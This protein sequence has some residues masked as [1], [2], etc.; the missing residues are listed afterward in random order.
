MSDLTFDN[1]DWE[2]PEQFYREIVLPRIEQLEKGNVLIVD[3]AEDTPIKT[4]LRHKINKMLRTCRHASIG[5]AYILHRIKSG[6]WTQQ[7]SSSCK[8][9]TLF[10]KS[11]KGKI[12]EFLKDQGLTSSEARTIVNDYG[13][14]DTR[15]MMVRLHAPQAFINKKLLR[16]F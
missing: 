15:A 1:G 4:Q 16:L 5:V 6:L 3:D 9:Y 12:I 7:S 8:Y 10:P 13:D 11:G 14:V 2:T